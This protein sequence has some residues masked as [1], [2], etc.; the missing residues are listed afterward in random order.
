MSDADE[1]ARRRYLRAASMPVGAHVDNTS[2]T[3]RQ[4]LRFRVRSISPGADYDCSHYGVLYNSNT[5]DDGMGAGPGARKRAMSGEVLPS[6]QQ[7]FIFEPEMGSFAQFRATSTNLMPH[8]QTGL[9]IAE[10]IVVQFL[11]AMGFGVALS[12][13]YPKLCGYALFPACIAVAI[14][15]ATVSS[16]A[17]MDVAVRTGATT[18]SELC[19]GLPKWMKALSEGCTVAWYL[20]LLSLYMQITYDSINDQVF[21]PMGTGSWPGGRAV[22][23][24]GRIAL[25]CCV[26][27]AMFLSTSP[28]NFSGRVAQVLN[29]VNLIATLMTITISIIKGVVVVFTDPERKAM[30]TVL[31]GADENFE[32]FTKSKT[33]GF[34]Q[35]VVLL[36]GAMCCCGS[37]PLLNNEIRDDCREEA[38]WRVPGVVAVLQGL[39]FMAV[40][41][42]GYF[43]LGN[44]ITSDAFKV[45]AAI[46]PDWMTT[47]IQVGITLLLYC[48]TPLLM[49]PPKSQCWSWIASLR[50]D[51]DDEG[52]DSAPALARHS[53]NAVLICVC[54]A[55]PSGLGEAR[56]LA[57]FTVVAGTAAVWNNLY[58][59]AFVL[60]Y[61]R[62]KPD[63]KAGRPWMGQ[64]VLALWIFMIATAAA[65]SAMVDI[66]ALFEPSGLVEEQQLIE[67][68]VD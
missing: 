1:D 57:L 50:G 6:F 9:S 65:I 52:L 67:E 15:T 31:A 59:P 32:L 11:S 7:A 25:Y 35:V 38:V 34:V 68:L 66:M 4:H 63:R 26:G 36:S 16:A 24:D 2:S 21:T 45:Y 48:S 12:A 46:Y 22:D 13:W 5:G 18:F 19:V 8:A 33:S 14:F 30:E 56:F 23:G 49:L 58:L 61:M 62:I 60:I 55:L 29:T 42:S 27:A 53:L 43:A 17:V 10:A 47:A 40:G 44:T 3:M 54:T 28:T 51:E 20:V 37:M 39:I 41:L 64:A